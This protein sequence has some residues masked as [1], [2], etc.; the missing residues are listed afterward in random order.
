L[1]TSTSLRRV[2]HFTGDFRT[3]DDGGR[4]TQLV[5]R[6]HAI[7]DDPVLLPP[8][9]LEHL[10]DAS[11]PPCEREL[12]RGHLRGH[13]GDEIVAADERIQRVDERPSHGNRSLNV[14]VT[15]VEE[16]HEDPRARIL[17]GA[18]D[19]L[20]RRGVRTNRLGARTRHRHALELHDLL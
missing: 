20:H 1:S 16:E 13:D 4:V 17:G 11:R 9:A 7:V 14:D 18:P 2:D 15:W 12:T 3:I 19:V 6:F 8:E 10:L 5:A